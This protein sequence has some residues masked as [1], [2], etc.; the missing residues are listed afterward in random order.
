MHNKLLPEVVQTLKD[1]DSGKIVCFEDVY[2]L[3]VP[4]D[5]F[6]PFRD[7]VI[8]IIRTNNG[9]HIA[10]EGNEQFYEQF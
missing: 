10:E 7:C 8:K 3:K 2:Y 6:S 9:W 5:M 1:L 4:K